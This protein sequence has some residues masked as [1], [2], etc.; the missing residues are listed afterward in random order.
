[1]RQSSRGRQPFT[2]WLL[3]V[4]PILTP[5][6]AATSLSSS[7]LPTAVVAI[8]AGTIVFVGRADWTISPCRRVKVKMASKEP[9]S[10]PYHL[11]SGMSSSGP[12]HYVK[13]VTLVSYSGV[14]ARPRNASLL[15]HDA[16]ARLSTSQ[17]GHYL[18]DAQ[19]SAT[20][21]ARAPTLQGPRVSGAS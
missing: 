4:K 7:P 17:T 20:A 6:N 19:C 21:P 16:L 10:A 5:R 14:H 18:F 11:P 15:L 13:K 8:I 9:D 1:M 12:Y 3:L 2:S